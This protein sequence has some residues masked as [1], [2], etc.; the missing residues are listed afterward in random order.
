[1]PRQI[2]KRLVRSRLNAYSNA[3]PIGI[4][5]VHEKTRP[6]IEGEVENEE[7]ER[8]VTGHVHKVI[9]SVQVKTKAD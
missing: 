4:P 5:L 6:E 7:A 3:Y 9:S 8:K 1:L 2:R